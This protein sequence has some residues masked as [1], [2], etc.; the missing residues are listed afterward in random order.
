MFSEQELLAKDPLYW[1]HACDRAI[2]AILQRA[3]TLA[4]ELS[5]RSPKPVNR[6]EIINRFLGSANRWEMN[7]SHSTDSWLM[8]LTL[9]EHGDILYGSSKQ[10]LRKGAI[11]D[12]ATV[13][14]IYGA[15]YR[16]QFKYVKNARIILPPYS[17]IGGFSGEWHDV[18]K[19][20]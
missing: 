8:P 19:K 18:L 10:R 9:T 6:R 5:H 20:K 16:L 17:Y 2:T 14:T 12:P 13:K 15:L 4:I 1:D 11:N 7:V 3:R